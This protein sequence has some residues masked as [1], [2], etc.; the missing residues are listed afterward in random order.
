[1][2]WQGLGVWCILGVMKKVIPPASETLARIRVIGVGGSG[3]NVTNHMIKSAVPGV[4]F[5]V[6]N[7]DAQDL[8]QSKAQKK[9]HLGKRTT[10]GLGTGMNPALGRSAAEESLQ[11]INEELK[12][13]DLVFIACGM[14][15]GT[16]TGAAPVVAKAAQDLN[17]LTVAVITKPFTFEGGKRREIAEEG[18]QELAKHTDAMVTIPNDNILMAASDKTTMA[19]AFTLSD[20]ILLQAVSGIAQLIIKPGDINIDFADIR[21][22]LED[23]GVSL[24][25]LGI[26]RGVNKAEV[27]V[28]RAISSPL[29]ETSIKGAQRALFS[30]ASRTRSDISM[31]EVQTIAERITESVDPNAKIIFG[32]STDRELRQGEIRITLIATAFDQDAADVSSEEE[33]GSAKK[34]ESSSDS[35]RPVEQLSDFTPDD[36][37]QSDVIFD[38]DGYTDTNEDED[39]S[40]E[41]EP[42]TW[43]NLWNKR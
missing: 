8:Q 26:G 2:C 20:E 30:I 37:L 18:L 15:G 41:E 23:S 28:T 1:M 40:P 10:Q 4:E 35:D 21:A 13:A 19:E 22:I 5:I 42:S 33:S 43:K 7:T 12:G 9:I 39:V 25:G 11:E 17:I 6:A 24:L 27:A 38:E 31:R 32:T 16:G 3:K 36:T 14:G 34:S 29:L